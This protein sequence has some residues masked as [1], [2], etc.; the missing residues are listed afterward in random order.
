M[1]PYGGSIPFFKMAVIFTSKSRNGH[2]LV[3]SEDIR[4]ILVAYRLSQSLWL[5]VCF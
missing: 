2:K 3:N 1:T 4:F 5:N